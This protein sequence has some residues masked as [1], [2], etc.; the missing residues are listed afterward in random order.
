MEYGKRPGLELLFLGLAVF[1]LVFLCA[2]RWEPKKSAQA[3]A[4][5]RI[6]ALE[7]ASGHVVLKPEKPGI[8]PQ[9]VPGLLGD[10]LQRW[11]HANPKK[12]IRA[13]ASIVSGGNTTEIHLWIDQL[14]PAKK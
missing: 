8:D 9:R 5:M 3:A 7:Y 1:I 12:K 4:P 13:A 6:A 11:M 14:A 2:S 10:A